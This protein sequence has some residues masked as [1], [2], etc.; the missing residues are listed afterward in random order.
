MYS[1][2]AT[3]DVSLLFLWFFLFAIGFKSLQRS[4]TK[5]SGEVVDVKIGQENTFTSEEGK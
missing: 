5:Q 3:H 1:D 4:T 2:L